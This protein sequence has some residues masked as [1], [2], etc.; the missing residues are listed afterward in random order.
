[1]LSP[2]GL[3]CGYLS[4]ERTLSFYRRELENERPLEIAARP[5]EDDIHQRQAMWRTQGDL[6]GFRASIP[7][8]RVM[9]F[10]AA[11]GPRPWVADA[12]LGIVLGSY[13]DQEDAALVRSSAQAAGGTVMLF[14]R[15]ARLIEY[16]THPAERALLQRL[17]QAFDPDGR[18]APL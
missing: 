18:L 6:P 5:L 13:H 8:A 3:F 14:D 1:M 11:I 17:K 12:A 16:P 4:D 7:P 2:D 15:D 10:T 9:E